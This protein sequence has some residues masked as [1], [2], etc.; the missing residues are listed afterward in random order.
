M[1]TNTNKFPMS[2]DDARIAARQDEYATGIDPRIGPME[3]RLL[4]VLAATQTPSD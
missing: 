2:P 4:L 1:N 3:Y